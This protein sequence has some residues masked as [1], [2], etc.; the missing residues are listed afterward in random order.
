MSSGTEDLCYKKR[1][2]ELGLFGLAKE[3]QRQEIM[4][5]YRYIEE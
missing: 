2:K 3:D 5:L 4:T 1:Q